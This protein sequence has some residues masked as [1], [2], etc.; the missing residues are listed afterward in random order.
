MDGRAM[1]RML[2]V[3]LRREEGL[4]RR[5]APGTFRLSGLRE[6]VTKSPPLLGLRRLRGNSLV[7][8]WLR[9]RVRTRA[10]RDPEPLEKTPGCRAFVDCSSVFRDAHEILADVTE[11]PPRAPKAR[12]PLSHP[13]REAGI[14]PASWG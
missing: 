4:V 7:P 1:A 3:T 9:L 13:L 6:R 2:S 8:L 10:L 12:L 11:P 14:T 5:T